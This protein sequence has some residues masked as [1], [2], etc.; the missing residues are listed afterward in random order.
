MFTCI[1]N[2]VLTTQPDLTSGNTN[3]PDL[4]PLTGVGSSTDKVCSPPEEATR[5]RAASS[6]DS[7][8][9]STGSRVQLALAEGI[10]TM[11]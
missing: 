1:Q 5:S 9:G 6:S 8:D 4:L 3:K 10:V 11:T 7:S 2:F